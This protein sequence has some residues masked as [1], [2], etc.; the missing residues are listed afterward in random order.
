MVTAQKPFNKAIR[1]ARL[2][3][4]TSS[5]NRAYS[6]PTCSNNKLFEVTTVKNCFPVPIQPTRGVNE[7]RVSSCGFVVDLSV[8]NVTGSTLECVRHFCTWTSDH[9]I[10]RLTLLSDYFYI[11]WSIGGNGIRKI[12][13]SLNSLWTILIVVISPNRW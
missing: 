1:Y 5:G 6:A 10:H 7:N 9:I 4:F 13:W 3:A 2:A 12:N 11:K 8:R